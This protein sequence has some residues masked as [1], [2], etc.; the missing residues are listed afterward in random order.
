MGELPNQSSDSKASLLSHFHETHCVFVSLARHLASFEPA[1]SVLAVSENSSYENWPSVR[2]LKQ[3]H[4]VCYGCGREAWALGQLS[5]QICYDN[6][7]NIM[8]TTFIGRLFEEQKL[9]PLFTSY[10][11]VMGKSSWYC[12]QATFPANLKFQVSLSLSAK[13]SVRYIRYESVLNVDKSV[14]YHLNR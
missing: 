6:D 12:K 4:S 8:I 2:P 1:M 9:G 14:G 13:A 11:F 10:D 3:N 7:D 5:D